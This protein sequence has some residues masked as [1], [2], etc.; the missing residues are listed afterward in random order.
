MLSREISATKNALYLEIAE[1][2]A[3]YSLRE[4]TAPGGGFYS[5]QDADS[6]GEE[7]KYYL[8]VPEEIKN[9]LG[10]Q[11]SEDFCRHFDITEEGNFE[12]KNIPNLLKS[13]YQKTYSDEVLERVLQYRR[14]RNFLHLDDKILES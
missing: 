9:L 14:E 5:A 1:K 12:G 8:F 10:Q 11:E 2:T 13:D 6:D 7:G 3:A 4:M